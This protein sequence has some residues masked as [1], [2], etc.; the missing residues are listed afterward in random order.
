[1]IWK[2]FIVFLFLLSKGYAQKQENEYKKMIDSAISIMCQKVLKPTENQ[3]AKDLYLIDENNLDYNYTGMFAQLGFK[4]IN[5][6]D[7]RNISVLKKGIHAWQI[8][9]V[10]H[11]HILKITI[12]EFFITY[13]SRNYNFGNGGGSETIFEYS[14]SENKWLLV[15]SDYR[16]L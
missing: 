8:F 2:L 11:D 6:L 9:P 4:R 14:C 7:S 15:K 16:G 10:L 12:I 13:K 5:V 1:M 3:G